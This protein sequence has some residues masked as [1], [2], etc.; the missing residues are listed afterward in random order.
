MTYMEIILTQVRK[1][2][3][4][5]IVGGYITFDKSDIISSHFLRRSPI[6]D[7]QSVVEMAYSDIESLNGYF[8]D[9]RTCNIFLKKLLIGME[10]K[11]V[12]IWIG[13]DGEDCDIEL[14]FLEEQFHSMQNSELKCNLQKLIQR[15]MQFY[16]DFQIGDI[17]LGY[18]PA[19]DEDMKVLE[20]KKGQVMCFNEYIH[21]SPAAQV[22]YE[23][24]KEIR[25]NWS[26]VLDIEKSINGYTES[27]SVL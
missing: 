14:S 15:L 21:Q 10:M 4:D 26:T 3:L 2:D 12:F 23:L 8:Q 1:T 11:D 22:L 19:Q 18:E 6:Q 7:K 25:K 5:R 16:D 27:Q 13:C 20:I 24:A 17:I 9:A